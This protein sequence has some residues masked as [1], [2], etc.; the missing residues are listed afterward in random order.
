[1]YWKLI[2]IFFS[3]PAN[4]SLNIAQ[5]TVKSKYNSG[6]SDVF[7]PI[8]QGLFTIVGGY[9]ILLSN[10]GLNFTKRQKGEE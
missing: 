7:T 4:Q 6:L 2:G 10:S 9:V 3:K 5:Y 8:L 1:M